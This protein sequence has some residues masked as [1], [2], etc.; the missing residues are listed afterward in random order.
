MANTTANAASPIMREALGARPARR[1]PIRPSGITSRMKAQCCA[2]G[3]STFSCPIDR[4]ISGINQRA[5]N[6]PTPAKVQPSCDRNTGRPTT[7]QT[8]RAPKR[9]SLAADSQFIAGL[10]EKSAE[11]VTFFFE[12]PRSD[13]KATTVPRSTATSPAAIAMSAPMKPRDAS[14]TLPTKKPAPLRA[15]F[16][17][18]SRETHLKSAP[19]APSGTTTLMALFALIFV[20]SLAMPDSAWA[21]IT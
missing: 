19:S 18:V 5:I 7:N 2:A 12:R 17:P 6:L 13:G 21:A 8:S 1:A 4:R 11:N 14:K 15:F 9:K 16:E 20:K 3:P 10:L